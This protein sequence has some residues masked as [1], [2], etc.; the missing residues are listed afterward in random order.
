MVEKY[1]PKVEKYKSVQEKRRH[2]ATEGRRGEGAEK[3]LLKK[4][5]KK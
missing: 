4:G 1:G 5:K 2:E 3:S